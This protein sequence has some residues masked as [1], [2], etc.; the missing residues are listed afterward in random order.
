ML[1]L[2]S[3][4]SVLATSLYRQVVALSPFL[5]VFVNRFLLICHR[6]NGDDTPLGCE[7]IKWRCEVSCVAVDIISD[8]LDAH[9]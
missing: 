5:F 8:S 9:S 3:L 7:G 4:H 2:D 1:N 6:R